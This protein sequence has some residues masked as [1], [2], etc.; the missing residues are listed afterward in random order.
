M[1]RE[2]MSAT[3]AVPATT[4]VVGDSIVTDIAGAAALGLYSVYVLSGIAQ[5]RPEPRTAAPSL[6]LP[7]V[8]TL[9][10]ALQRTRPDLLES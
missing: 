10:P 3:G 2:L 4:V 7:S 6:T 1:F 8:A 5:F 9:I